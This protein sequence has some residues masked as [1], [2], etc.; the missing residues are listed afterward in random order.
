VRTL[1]TKVGA[2]AADCWP[3]LQHLAVNRPEVQVQ[4]PHDPAHAMFRKP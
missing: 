3:I 2:D 1:A 4:R